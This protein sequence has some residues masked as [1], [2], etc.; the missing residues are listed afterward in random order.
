M[1]LDNKFKQ[2]F[3]KLNQVFLYVI[4]ECNL[5]CKYCLYKPNIEF[6]LK[7]KEIPYK[8]AIKLL[9]EFRKLGASKLTII[10]G[11]PT[12]YGISKRWKPLLNLIK[13]SKQLGYEYVRIDTNGMFNSR[14]LD[15]KEFKLL[16]EITFSL[17]SHNSKINDEVRGKG[18]FKKCVSN[19]K[20]AVKKGYNID[21]TST[22]H[23]G[24]IGKAK[25]G[26]ILLHKMILFAQSIGANRINFHPIFKM[27]I[28]RDTW[29][30]D[31]FIEPEDW[32]NVYKK[33]RMNIKSLKYKINVRISKCFVTKKEFN[34]NKNYYSYCPINLGERILVH[35]NG[36]MRICALMIGSPYGIGR[37]C[38][39][40]IVFDSTATSELVCDNSKNHPCPV[41]KL[42]F[43]KYLP[44]CISFKPEQNEFIW[45]KKLNWEKKKE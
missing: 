3:R 42:N 14:L 45:Q 38:D 20:L 11:E 35:P 2:H 33:I 13:K 43:G 41:Q 36:M 31:V 28:P 15:K 29:A 21:I 44:L 19:I 17:D 34:K 1:K 39:S 4:D 7:N 32:I 40:N 24:N 27:G 10:G 16:D 22:V 8:T 5:R 23:K 37:Y 6:K 26:E 30:E 9:S 12:L 25:D 18:V